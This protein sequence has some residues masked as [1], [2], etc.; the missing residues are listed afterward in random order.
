MPFEMHFRQSSSILRPETIKGRRCQ[1]RNNANYTSSYI[2]TIVRRYKLYVEFINRTCTHKQTLFYIHFKRYKVRTYVQKYHFF[3]FAFVCTTST[4]QAK[5]LRALCVCICVLYCAQ[6]ISI[7]YIS[8]RR[9][10]T[11]VYTYIASGLQQ[12]ALYH[13]SVNK[14]F[15]LNVIVIADD[16][17]FFFLSFPSQSYTRD[18][19]NLYFVAVNVTSSS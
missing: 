11:Y 13:S 6:C 8:Y 12:D 15:H 17:V 2:Y 3:S 14:N 9:V 19:S 1:V 5:A 4:Y 7:Y 10:S 16:M 18:I